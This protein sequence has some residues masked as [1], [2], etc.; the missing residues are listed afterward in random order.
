[1]EL[2][3]QSMFDFAFQMA[4]NVIPVSDVS[5][6]GKGHCC[7]ELVSKTWQIGLD[8]ADNEAVHI[9]CQRHVECLIDVICDIGVM[10]GAEMSSV[11]SA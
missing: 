5:D 8:T 10:I 11:F 7:S 2:I 1:M 4:W 9:V 3:L 6:P